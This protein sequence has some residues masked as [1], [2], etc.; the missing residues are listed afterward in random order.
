MYVYCVHEFVAVVATT[1]IYSYATDACYFLHVFAQF[2]SAVLYLSHS[3]SLFPRLRRPYVAFPRSQDSKN[4]VKKT[5]DSLYRMHV[6]KGFTYI[7]AHVAYTFDA[8][9]TT[10]N[11]YL[12]RIYILYVISGRQKLQT[13]LLIPSF[14][15]ISTFIL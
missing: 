14:H 3:L 12:P 7:T 9:S 10:N 6:A 11:I 4:I 8:G 15:I 5:T 2:L 1:S 13:K